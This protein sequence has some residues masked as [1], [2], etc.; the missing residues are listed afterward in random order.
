[1]NITMKS[2]LGV[3]FGLLA[4]QAVQATGLIGGDT[5]N[6]NTNTNTNLTANSNDNRNTNTNANAY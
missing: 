2:M 1:M 6:T 5:R 3:V 4:A